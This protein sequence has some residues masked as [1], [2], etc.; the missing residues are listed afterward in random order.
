MKKLVSLLIVMV[1]CSVI[2]LPAAAAEFVPSISYKDHPDVVVDPVITPDTSTTEELDILITPVAD[3]LAVKPEDRNDA[4]KELVEI[5]EAL[6]NGDMKLPL[7]DDKNY[8]VRDLMDVSL[9]VKNADPNADPEFVDADAKVVITFDLGVPEDT[10]V[11]AY[12]YDNDWVKVDVVNNGDGTVTVTLHNQGALA[13]CV[14]EKTIVPPT[15]DKVGND[16]LF[17]VVLMVVS[18]CAAVTMVAVRRKVRR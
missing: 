1:L 16:L 12:V 9:I 4:E 15:F 6:T 13:F 17:W 2:V 3:A 7:P 5:Y 11:L 18:S 14:D 8:V 10:E